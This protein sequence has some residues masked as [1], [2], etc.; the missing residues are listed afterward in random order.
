MSACPGLLRKANSTNTAVREARGSSAHPSAPLPGRRS[1]APRPSP[2]GK[3]VLRHRCLDPFLRGETIAG[4]CHREQK[5][6]ANSS[7]PEIH[8]SQA[9]PTGF[10]APLL[11]ELSRGAGETPPERPASSCLPVAEC[12]WN[13]RFAFGSGDRTPRRGPDRSSYTIVPTPSFAA[14]R[15]M[16]G[17]SIFTW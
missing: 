3:D 15:A 11:P 12:C 14:L 2:F 13:D 5:R 16:M 7:R 17:I 4:R 6:R 10:S 1:R 8:G 9:V